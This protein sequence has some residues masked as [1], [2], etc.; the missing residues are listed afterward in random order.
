MKNLLFFTAA[1]LLLPESTAAYAIGDSVFTRAD[2][3]SGSEREPRCHHRPGFVLAMHSQ[4]FGAHGVIR[5][6]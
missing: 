3:W 1:A 6:L 4:S 2:K 5:N